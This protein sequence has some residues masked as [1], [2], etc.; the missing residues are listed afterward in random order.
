ME[1]IVCGNDGSIIE[2]KN[3][4]GMFEDMWSCHTCKTYSFGTFTNARD[5]HIWK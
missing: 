5:V 3:Q 4:G 2:I 1:V